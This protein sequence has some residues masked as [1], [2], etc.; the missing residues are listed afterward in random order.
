MNAQFNELEGYAAYYTQQTGQ[1]KEATR[2]KMQ[3]SP[4]DILLTNYMML[5]LLLTRNNDG[6]PGL[7]QSIYDNL[8]FLACDEL[9]TF[10]GRQ[11][12][13][14]AL[15]TRRLISRA[16]HPVIGTWATMVSG[17]TFAEQK[18][19]IAEVATNH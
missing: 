7:R 17:G 10:R 4:P 5:E 15:L 13:D 9:H 19:R 6:E 12:A 14:A 3:E 8:R 18:Q 1:E 16:K 11:G 2:R